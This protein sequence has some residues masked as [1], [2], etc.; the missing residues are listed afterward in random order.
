MPKGATRIERFYAKGTVRQED[1]RKDR[2]G[3][4]YRSPRCDTETC[5]GCARHTQRQRNVESE[6]L[7]VRRRRA[8]REIAPTLGR[9]D[10]TETAISRANHVVEQF[11]QKENQVVLHPG[12]I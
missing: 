1:S 11:R 3:S 4:L 9:V 2:G 12:K 5:R 6:H 7:F 8:Q 10:T